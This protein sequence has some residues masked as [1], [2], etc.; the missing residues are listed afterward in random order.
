MPVLFEPDEESQ[1]PSGL[2]IQETLTIIK[3][4]K[5]TILEIPVFNNT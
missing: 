5:S 4:G 3:R 2:I 1:W